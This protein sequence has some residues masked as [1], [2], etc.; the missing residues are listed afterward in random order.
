[1]EDEGEDE[2]V[3]EE[4]RD[5]FLDEPAMAEEIDELS[6]KNKPKGDDVR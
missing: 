1:M 5:E 3:V 6:F 4:V 2:G